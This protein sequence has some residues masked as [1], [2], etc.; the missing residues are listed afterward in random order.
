M[1]L[2]EI[3]CCVEC[4]HYPWDGWVRDARCCATDEQ[5]TDPKPNKTNGTINDPVNI[6]NEVGKKCPLEDAA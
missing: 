5:L 4:K 6:Y 1:K 3:S 2:L